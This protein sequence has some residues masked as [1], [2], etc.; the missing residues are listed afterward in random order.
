[1]RKFKLQ[2]LF[3]ILFFSLNNSTAQSVVIS[4]TGTILLKRLK[5]SSNTYKV[6]FKID[7]K[8]NPRVQIWKRSVKDTIY[9][10]RSSVL[11]THQI[12]INDTL[13]DWAR[14]ICDAKTMNSL[15]HTT[16]SKQRGIEEF[17]F[18]NVELRIN[19]QLITSEDTSQRS[20]TAL[21]GF[22][23]ATTMNALNW[24]ADL[25]LLPLLPFKDSA[26]IVVPFY[27]PGSSGPI[28]AEY[29]VMGSDFHIDSNGEQFDCWKVRYQNRS[30]MIFWID[31]KN[32]MVRK[33]EEQFGKNMYRF[34]VLID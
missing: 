24:H 22:L 28:L 3:I 2:Y 25:E 30:I 7:D 8:V 29:R 23:K 20:K 14:S 4:D 21:E 31:K 15:Y 1:M 33:L 18:L 32:G 11:F 6:Y 19:H 13:V 34:K 16:W 12:W 10:E 26:V 17:D 27:H 5:S 9:A